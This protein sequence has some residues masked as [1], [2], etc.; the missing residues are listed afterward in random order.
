LDFVKF[1]E[2]KKRRCPFFSFGERRAFYFKM[3]SFKAMKKNKTLK[4]TLEEK[5]EQI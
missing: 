2:N 5:D 3:I 1:L 4:E